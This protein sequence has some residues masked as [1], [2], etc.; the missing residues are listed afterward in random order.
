MRAS[1]TIPQAA[2]TRHRTTLTKTS[3]PGTNALPDRCARTAYELRSASL[4][5]RNLPRVVVLDVIGN[6]GVWG[7][8]D[9]NS[10]A[11]G[12]AKTRPSQ[13]N[14]VEDPR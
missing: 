12:G 2:S 10:A 3:P 13:R 14:R 7:H 9:L 6:V 8:M 5:R 4:A 11:C 1:Q